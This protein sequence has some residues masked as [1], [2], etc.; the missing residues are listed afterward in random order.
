M[1][2]TVI[3]LSTG[4]VA[5]FCVYKIIC[6]L[7]TRRPMRGDG[8]MQKETQKSIWISGVLIAANVLG[9]AYLL[10]PRKFEEKKAQ[11]MESIRN[12]FKSDK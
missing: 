7:S 9:L 12:F 2:K 4:A 6:I 10:N 8:D 11:L 5:V 3:V 1:I